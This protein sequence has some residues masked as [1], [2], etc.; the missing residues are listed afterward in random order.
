MRSLQRRSNAFETSKGGTNRGIE[1][2]Q[3]SIG[4]AKVIRI[5]GK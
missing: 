5:L 2:S 4:I 1:K 3:G